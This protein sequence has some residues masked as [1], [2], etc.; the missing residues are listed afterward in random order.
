MVSL[1][2][3]S[4]QVAFALAHVLARLATFWRFGYFRPSD[5]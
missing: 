3:W 1:R 4:P 2:D 5:E